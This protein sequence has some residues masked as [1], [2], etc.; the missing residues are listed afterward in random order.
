M[1]A[2]QAREIAFGL[3]LA[4]AQLQQAVNTILAAIAP[5]RNSMRT[6]V[7]INPRS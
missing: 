4:P 3:G 2:F 5:S 6:M 7:E 1:Q